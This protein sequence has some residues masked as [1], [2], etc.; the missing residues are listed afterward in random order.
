MILVFIFL[1][2]LSLFG[3][4]PYFQTDHKPSG[5]TSTSAQK[6]PIPA[7]STAPVSTSPTSTPTQAS[8]GPK[9]CDKDP[10]DVKVLKSD[11]PSLSLS[12]NVNTCAVLD[13]ASSPFPT[14]LLGT[15]T[16]VVLKIRTLVPA[17][18]KYLPSGS[19]FVSLSTTDGLSVQGLSDT[20]TSNAF[21]LIATGGKISASTCRFTL[22]GG[23]VTVTQEGEGWIVAVSGLG[24]GVM[25]LTS[26]C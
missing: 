24:S 19:V 21:I 14:W 11:G 26:S 5:A 12:F 23:E 3:V 8:A 16:D 15:S 20:S 7:T 4:H 6:T 13:P 9:L 17:T 18:G 2:T 22:Q 1:G 10:R 25:A